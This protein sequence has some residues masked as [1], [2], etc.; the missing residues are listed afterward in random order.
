MNLKLFLH[1]FKSITSLYENYFM[2]CLQIPHGAATFLPYILAATQTY[3]IYLQPSDTI[4]TI[5]V[6]SAQ[7]L[8]PFTTF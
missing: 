7:I 6:P 4:F 5:A 1:Y 3:F 2:C 8:N